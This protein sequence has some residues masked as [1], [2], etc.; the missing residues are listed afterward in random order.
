MP[1]SMKII[2]Q[3]DINAQHKWKSSTLKPENEKKFSVLYEKN[4][5]M[6]LE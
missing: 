2:T 5:F 1:Y 6:Y 4:V 3:I